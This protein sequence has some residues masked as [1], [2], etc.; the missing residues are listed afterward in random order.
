MCVGAR[1]R[2]LTL[3]DFY[4]DECVFANTTEAVRIR[5]GHDRR[6]IEWDAI[7]SYRPPTAAHA[8]ATEPSGV[9]TAIGTAF[10]GDGTAIE[11]V[12]RHRDAF[13]FENV[14]DSP[15][16]SW[17][18]DGVGAKVRQLAR[19]AKDGALA[20]LGLVPTL[21]HRDQAPG[22]WLDLRSG[23]NAYGLPRARAGE[24]AL[25]DECLVFKPGKGEV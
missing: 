21:H 6:P 23:R 20:W 10:T 11:D 4:L 3:A 7:G 8:H 19:D 18:R 9:S 16:A 12:I 24:R 22:V 17:R 1:V 2:L 5:V 13:L 25:E 15:R 14:Y